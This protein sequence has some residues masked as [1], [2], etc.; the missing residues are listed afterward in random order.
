MSPKKNECNRFDWSI[1]LRNMSGPNTFV[2]DRIKQDKLT[3]QFLS[4]V[5]IRYSSC[6]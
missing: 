1:M 6:G 4:I 5:R 2:K 3:I